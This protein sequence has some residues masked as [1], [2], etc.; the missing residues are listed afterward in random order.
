MNSACH[1]GQGMQRGK[2]CMIGD[3]CTTGKKTK[4]NKTTNFFGKGSQFTARYE[5]V[6]KRIQFTGLRHLNS[7]YS[8]DKS[9]LTSTGD[10]KVSYLPQTSHIGYVCSA[11]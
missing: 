3:V 1:K 5:L 9:Y 6:S 7:T 4:L 2:R 8:L 10:L 11:E